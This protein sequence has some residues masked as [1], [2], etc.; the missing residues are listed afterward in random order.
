MGLQQYL[1]PLELRQRFGGSSVLFAQMTM[2][3]SAK[4]ILD[5]LYEWIIMSFALEDVPEGLRCLKLIRWY[6]ESCI[7]ESSEYYITYT[8]DDLTSGKLDTTNFDIPSDMF[9]DPY[10]TDIEEPNNTM[11]IDTKKHIIRNN[12]DKLGQSAYITFFIDNNKETTISF[13]INT[14]SKTYIYLNGEIIDIISIPTNSKMIYNIPY[15]GEINTFRI[16]KLSFDNTDKDFFIGKIIIKDI[17][18][19]GKLEIDFKPDPNGNKIL[20]N[21]SKKIISYMNLYEDNQQLMAELVKGNTYLDKGY[22]RLSEYWNIH[23][24]HKEKGKRLTIKRT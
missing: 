18:K 3:Q 21:T 4:R 20:N 15:T 12:P 5:C 23:H 7:I 24:Q 11:F 13:Y 19:T 9:P 14:N 1:Y 16:E 10:Y 22:D 17:G 6:L 2:P 8:P